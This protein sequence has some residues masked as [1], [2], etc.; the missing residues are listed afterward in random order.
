MENLICHIFLTDSIYTKKFMIFILKHFPKDEHIFFTVDPV[1]YSDVTSAHVRKVNPKNFLEAREMVKTLKS[2]RKIILHSLFNAN[3]FPVLFFNKSLLKR[4][5][6]V[7]WGGD[8]YYNIEKR[9]NTNSLIV[10]FKKHMKKVMLTTIIRNLDS[11]AAFLKADYEYARQLFKTKARYRYVFYPN[12]VSFDILDNLEKDDKENRE[13]KRILVGNSA[14]WTNKHVEILEYLSNI[15]ANF[16]II[17]PLSYGDKAYAQNVI[18]IGQKLFGDR[19]KPLT[20]FLK[21]EEYSKVVNSVDIAI[22]NHR[23]QEAL[24]NVL[25]LLYLGK[26]VY[27][28]SETTPWEFF[29]EKG[30][31]IFD[32]NKLLDGSEDLFAPMNLDSKNKNREIIRDEFSEERCVKLWSA[33][34]EAGD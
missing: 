31:T 29:K 9:I 8:A 21:P 12:P 20:D 14:S 1:L 15:D 10:K 2:A 30:M 18:K 13:W 33:L 16:E 25:A 32:T 3:F 5:S 26:K 6:W 4:A 23:Q 11:V 28:R 22:F 34:F 24:G 19:F 27:I 7:I 17:C